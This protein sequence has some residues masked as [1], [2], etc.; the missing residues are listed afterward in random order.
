MPNISIKVPTGAFN[1]QQ[2]ERLLKRVSEAAIAHE[3]IGDDPRQR[4]VCW[5][6]IE[7]V[8]SV[9]WLCGGVNP[10]A[11]AI[12]CIVTVK[13]PAGVLDETMRRD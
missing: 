12:P 6:L 13:V 10:H 1:D 8:R 3:H 9:D 4:S 2:Q 11:Q 7:E 5:V